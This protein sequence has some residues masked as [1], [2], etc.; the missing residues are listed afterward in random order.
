[1]QKQ[2][3]VRQMSI[4]ATVRMLRDA[5]SVTTGIMTLK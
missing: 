5:G 1:M 2:V 4:D 3:V